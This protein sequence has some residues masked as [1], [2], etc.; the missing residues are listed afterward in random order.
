MQQQTESSYKPFISEFT[1]SWG[2]KLDRVETLVKR[3]R[4]V[5]IIHDLEVRKRLDRLAEAAARTELET[6]KISSQ[7]LLS[8]LLTFGF[9]FALRNVI[10]S[11]FHQDKISFSYQVI[12]DIFEKESALGYIILQIVLNHVQ[13]LDQNENI[14]LT[15]RRNEGKF[16]IDLVCSA[17]W[18]FFGN[19]G[20]TGRLN[21]FLDKLNGLGGTYSLTIGDDKTTLN[22]SFK[23]M[24]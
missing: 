19:N 2:Q 21:H 6:T 3:Q 7:V 22:L 11:Y 16:E 17:A 9:R 23:E 10:D 8:S 4:Q 5:Y 12:E 1:K 13:M 14:H 18:S 24:R 15:A 20:K